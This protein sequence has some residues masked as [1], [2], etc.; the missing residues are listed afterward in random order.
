MPGS[1]GN[2]SVRLN[3]DCIL[4]TPTGCSKYLLKPE[5]M[6][7]VDLE[8]RHISGSRKVTSEIAIHLAAYRVRADVNAVIHLILRLRPASPVQDGIG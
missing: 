1:S 7:I 6:V 8:G 2:L 5:D 4:A 3:G